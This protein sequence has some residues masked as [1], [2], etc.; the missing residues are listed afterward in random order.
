L[1]LAGRAL[2]EYIVFNRVSKSR[3]IGLLALACLAPSML[4]AQP[5]TLVFVLMP[6]N[7]LPPPLVVALANAAVFTVIV[8]VENRR[9]R[10]QP[11][12]TSPLGPADP[13]T[14]D[15]PTRPVGKD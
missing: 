15:P 14:I 10:T 2:L 9:A 4:L 13:A 12:P 6:H 5:L 7:S 3:V 11:D 1:F 8:I